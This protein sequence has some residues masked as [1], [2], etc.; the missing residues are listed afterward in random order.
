MLFQV[1]AIADNDRGPRYAEAVLNSLHET[2][3]GRRWG[4]LE[5]G[6]YQ[7]TVGLFVRV[8]AELVATFTHDFA[9]AYPGRTLT[10]LPDEVP[11]TAGQHVW[12]A[13]LR[14]SPDVFPLKTHRQFEDL[15]HRELADPLAGLLSALRARPK[16]CVDVRIALVIR[17][18]RANWYRTAARVVAR[19]E[20]GFRWDRLG[21][22]YAKRVRSQRWYVRGIAR[23]VGRFSTQA[24]HIAPEKIS[25]LEHGASKLLA[26]VSLIGPHAEKWSEALITARGIE[27][28][29]VLMG[30]RAQTKKH[31]CEAIEKA[32]EIALSHGEFRLRILRKLLDRQAAKQL[33]LPWLEEH[34]LTCGAMTEVARPS[35]S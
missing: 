32:R 34:P 30:L 12:S 23:I 14:L 25:G 4:C 31:S 24:K 15:L 5:L 33:P 7:G 3:R 19:I 11:D 8:P 2:N 9:D 35:A 26:D 10:A 20:Q 1:S 13:T 18:C 28:T 6:S 21:H 17:P 16:R 29:R 22:W 27:G